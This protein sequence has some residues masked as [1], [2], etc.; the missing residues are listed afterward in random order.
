MRDAINKLDELRPLMMGV[1]LP[2]ESY[3]TYLP[4]NTILSMLFFELRAADA[5]DSEVL[6]LV[7]DFE[8]IRPFYGPVVL[9][10]EGLHP[11]YTG[12]FGKLRSNE[13][14]GPIWSRGGMLS[15]YA[16]S[17]SKQ[18]DTGHILAD[19]MWGD[20]NFSDFAFD[21]LALLNGTYRPGFGS[22]FYGRDFSSV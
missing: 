11:D 22:S 18:F 19:V 4:I 1:N 16:H 21:L 9:R 5:K 2:N 14:M 12:K 3:P 6:D 10:G 13:P 20:V 7:R 17:G 15:G 8:T